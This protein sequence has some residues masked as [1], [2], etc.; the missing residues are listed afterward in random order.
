MESYLLYVVVVIILW[1]QARR[2]CVSEKN[3]VECVRHERPVGLFRTLHEAERGRGNGVRSKWA[4]A[5]I[6]TATRVEDV[7]R[8]LFDQPHFNFCFALSLAAIE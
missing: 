7:S 3:A 5:V 4:K 2:W 8:V 6:Q 1:V